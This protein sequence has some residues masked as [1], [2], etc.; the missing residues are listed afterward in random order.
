MIKPEVPLMLLDPGLTNLD[1]T[2]IT[3]DAIDAS[4]FQAWAEGNWQP[5]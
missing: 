5:S 3:G 2:M 4:C 1:L